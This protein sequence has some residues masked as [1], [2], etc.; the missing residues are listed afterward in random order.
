LPPFAVWLTGLPASGKSTIVSLLRPELEALDLTVEV[1]E[2]DDVRHILTPTPT[3]S[4]TERDVFYRAL[5]LLG[6][7]LVAHGVTVLF[8]ATATKRMYR[9]L[10]RTLI[11][12]FIEV[13]VECRWKSACS[14]TT[15]IPTVAAGRE[16]HR[17]CPAYKYPT[18]RQR[19]QNCGSTPPPFL[20]RKPYSRSSLSFGRD[21]SS[22]L[23]LSL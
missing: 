14:E 13:S 8:D 7:R 9:D 16:T 12:R 19:M 18:N 4:E 11:P 10:A 15:R 3:Y 2:S 22:R 6:A 1:L 17:P 20:R 23:T 5:A 21:G